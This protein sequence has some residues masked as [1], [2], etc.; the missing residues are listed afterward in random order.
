MAW[1]RTVSQ[2]EAEGDLAR[3]YRAAVA[4]A[5]KIFHIVKLQSISP[6]IMRPFLDLYMK[7]MYGPSGLTR[8]EREMV[9]TVVSRT[10][11]CHY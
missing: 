6:E 1:I 8:S 5:G 7:I 11:A 2:E 4:R 3:Q 10:N 9:A